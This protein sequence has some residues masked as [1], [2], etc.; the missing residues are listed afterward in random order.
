MVN[1]EWTATF[2][3]WTLKHTLCKEV[4]RGKYSILVNELASG[5]EVMSKEITLEE[6]I[7]KIDHFI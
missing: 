7:A 2:I 3:L 1:S 6:R 5:F 4:A